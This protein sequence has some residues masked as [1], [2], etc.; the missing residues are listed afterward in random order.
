M[1]SSEQVRALQG[2]I[3]DIW[4][5]RAN[6]NRLDKIDT[7]LDELATVTTRNQ[8]VL[9]EILVPQLE[10]WSDAT[11][12]LARQLPKMAAALDGLTNMVREIDL[13]QRALESDVRA[14]VARRDGAQVGLVSRLD[15]H[16]VEIA[17]HST[18]L[19]SLET[20]NRDERI[21]STAISRRDKKLIGVAV[22]C[23]S[24][25]TFIAAKFQWLVSLFR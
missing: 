18:R 19:T 11:D 17:S 3:A 25:A 12:E 13:R 10:K 9:D 21:A 16:A 1:S 2:A 7:K 15:S 14:E 22:A 24:V 4:A 5:E 20:K 6:G 8:T 23:A